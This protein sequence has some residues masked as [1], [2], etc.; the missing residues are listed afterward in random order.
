M[1]ADGRNDLLG[2]RF[3]YDSVFALASFQFCGH[4]DEYLVENTRRLC[5]MYVLPRFGEHLVCFYGMMLMKQV[6]RLELKW[7]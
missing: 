7:D 1:A 6:L 2:K 5:L 4:I 3:R